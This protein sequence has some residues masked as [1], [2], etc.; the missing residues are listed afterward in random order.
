MA[1]AIQATNLSVIDVEETIY[2]Y[3]MRALSTAGS[4]LATM[5]C[6]TG[7]VVSDEL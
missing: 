3:L 5:T 1:S 2:Q 4:T 6:V 7:V